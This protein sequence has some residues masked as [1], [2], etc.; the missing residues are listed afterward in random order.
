MPQNRTM[1]AGFSMRLPDGLRDRL[2]N[3]AAKNRRSMNSELI[4][5]LEAA[6]G[7]SA[8]EAAG[9]GFADTTPAASSNTTALQ[10]GDANTHG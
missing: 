4:Y 10:G 7:H 1:N 9:E 3:A 5:H 8:P 2:K 6:L